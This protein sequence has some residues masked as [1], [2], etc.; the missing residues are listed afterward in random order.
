MHI[1]SLSLDLHWQSYFWP[2]LVKMDLKRPILAKIAFASW[3][4]KNP[5]IF[6][7]SWKF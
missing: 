1:A 3:I 7:K 6:Q 4:L 5:K 2:F